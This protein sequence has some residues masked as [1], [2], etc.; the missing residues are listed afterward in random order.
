MDVILTIDPSGSGS[1]GVC[2][3]QKEG[4]RE[5]F[6][7]TEFKSNNWEEHF[8]FIL[9]LLRENKPNV[10]IFETTTYIERRMKNSV[11]LLKL[12]GAI[13]CL[14][15]FFDFIRLESIAVN[16][17]KAYKY[18]IQHN[19]LVLPELICQL[20]RGKGWSYQKQRIS[21]HQLDALIIFFLW[22]QKEL[23]S[24]EFQVSTK[25]NKGLKL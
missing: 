5:S 12:T 2:V 22:K 7:F 13:A 3:V 15:Y 4:I 16:R 1:T 10:V 11:D 14:R 24:I 21:L 17:V 23:N 25:E 6:S 19:E 18:K 8:L 20:G 9:N